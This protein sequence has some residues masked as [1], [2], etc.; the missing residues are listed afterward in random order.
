MPK[1]LEAK[2]DGSMVIR[3]HH[4]KIV[5][6]YLKL[7]RK[8]AKKAKHARKIE[9]KF[10]SSMLAIIFSAMTLEAFVNEAAE[11]CIEQEKIAAFN[12]LKKPYTRFLGE[13]LAVTRIRNIFREKWQSDIFDNNHDLLMACV[14]VFSLRNSLI[15]YNIEETAAIDYLPPLQYIQSSNGSVG[16]CIDF[17]QKPIRREPALVARIKPKQAVGAY[18]TALNILREWNKHAARPD[19]LFDFEL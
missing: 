18:S 8:H 5:L 1:V 15:H 6:I 16:F 11:N 12:G 17:M 4:V 3:K 13:P 19:S 10:E 14:E 2:L 7:A 9:N